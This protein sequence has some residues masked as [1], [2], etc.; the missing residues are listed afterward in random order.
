MQSLHPFKSTSRSKKDPP[1]AL[2]LKPDICE[3]GCYYRGVGV[4]IK[5][6]IP[7]RDLTPALVAEIGWASY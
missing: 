7:T 5:R 6:D 3:R 2:F 4:V 1:P